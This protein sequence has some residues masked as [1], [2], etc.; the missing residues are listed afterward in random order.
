[1]RRGFDVLLSPG[2]E[3]N[4]CNGCYVVLPMPL[5]EVGVTAPAPRPEPPYLRNLDL[6]N[7]GDPTSEI[8][9]MVVIGWKRINLQSA[10]LVKP[11]LRLPEHLK[12]RLKTPGAA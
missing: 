3:G 6:R 12:R 11:M 2:R 9:M 7:L 5:P 8:R 4:Y 10:V 1:M